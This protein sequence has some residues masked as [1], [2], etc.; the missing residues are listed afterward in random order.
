[1]ESELRRALSGTA[2]M[3]ARVSEIGV[4][5]NPPNGSA[6]VL[7]LNVESPGLK[8]LHE[9][10]VDAFGAVPNLEGEEY[11]IHVTLARGGDRKTAERL[12][13]RQVGPYSW[14]VSELHVYDATYEQPAARIPLPA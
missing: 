13:G 12:A 14:T 6:P 9:R 8:A 10:M 7:Y 5:E 1:M 3:E 11:V 4:F 2:P